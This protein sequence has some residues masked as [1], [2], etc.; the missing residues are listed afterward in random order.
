MKNI[1]SGTPQQKSLNESKVTELREEM[2]RKVNQFCEKYV[3][4]KSPD[5]SEFKSDYESLFSQDII[6]CQL[7]DLRKQINDRIENLIHTKGV[8]V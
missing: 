8:E 3:S 6:C 4:S 1:L 5:L 7:G 2:G